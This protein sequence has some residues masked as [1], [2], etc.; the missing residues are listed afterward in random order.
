MSSA[1]AITYSAS[2]GSIV[3]KQFVSKP[4]GDYDN[5]DAAIRELYRE[6]VDSK[7]ILSE[8]MPALPEEMMTYET[9]DA[10][11]KQ[12]QK[13]HPI[14]QRNKQVDVKYYAHDYKNACTPIIHGEVK[15]K[16]KIV[17]YISHTEPEC[18]YNPYASYPWPIYKP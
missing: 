15:G 5:E 17:C 8:N 9:F 2:F 4:V 16:T 7:L 13:D 12:L 6:I 18:T 1:A 11:L 10:F 14:D 3:N